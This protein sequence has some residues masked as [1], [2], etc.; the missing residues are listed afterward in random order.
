ME[1]YKFLQKV[2]NELQY[3][4]VYIATHEDKGQVGKVLEIL[5]TYTDVQWQSGDLPTKVSYDGY[6]CLEIYQGISNKSLMCFCSSMPS[7]KSHMFDAQDLIGQANL[8]ME[9]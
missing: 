8:Y 1:F 7:S 6:T 4:E 9:V 3:G 5:E 2:R